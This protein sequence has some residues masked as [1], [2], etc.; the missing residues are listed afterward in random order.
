MMPR[1]LLWIAFLLISPSLLSVQSHGAP[2]ATQPI[3]SVAEVDR[4]FDASVAEARRQFHK[5]VAKAN[6]RRI[7]AFRSLENAA[8]DRKDLDLALAARERLKAA[9]AEPIADVVTSVGPTIVLH[10]R[11][12]IDGSDVCTIRQDKAVW[13][14][15]DWQ[16]AGDVSINE[17]KWDVQNQ[18]ELLNTGE[19]KFLSTTVDFSTAR[20]I[21]RKGRGAVAVEPIDNSL[22]IIFLDSDSGADDYG[23]D[24]EVQSAP[25]DARTAK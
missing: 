22:V 5:D 10:V 8:M 19:T 17:V 4:D 2:P 3:S 6:K 12:K 18:S 13:V 7:D 16:M 15:R 20:V 9:Q 14:H 21:S 11:A 24:I 23:V 1:R 25:A